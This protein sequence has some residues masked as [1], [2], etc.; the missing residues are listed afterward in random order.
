MRIAL[1]L[2]LCFAIILYSHPGALDSRGGHNDK[3][4]GG[5]HYHS[6]A[7]KS[8]NNPTTSSSK[9]NISTIKSNDVECIATVIDG[10]TIAYKTK[11]GDNITVKLYGIDAPDNNQTYGKEAREYL[12]NLISNKTINIKIIEKDRGIIF[13]GSRNINEE[14]L[15][16]GNAWVYVDYCKEPYLKKWQELEK[17]AKESKIG[18]WQNE[19]ALAPWDFRNKK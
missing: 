14:L 11:S 10:D 5:Y 8:A 12:N 13:L 9:Q 15:N 3:K 7:S 17:K 16:T 18:L 1:I 2:H 6:Q 19:T 4:S